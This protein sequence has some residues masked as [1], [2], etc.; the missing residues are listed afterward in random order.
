M[1]LARHAEQPLVEWR[2]GVAT[3]M[4]ASASSGSAELCLMEQRCRPGAGAP[5]HVHPAAEEVVVVLAGEA[6]VV[7]EDE[8]AVLRAGDAVVF[9]AGARHGFR[10]S[11]EEEL[12]ILASFSSAAPLAAYEGAETF[13]IGGVGG[14]RRDAHRAYAGDD[15]EGA[16]P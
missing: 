7:V 16:S 14:R 6:E 9:P 2:D 1:L 5:L 12:R 3:R 8:Q 13:E 11:G 15:A 10:N 4:L